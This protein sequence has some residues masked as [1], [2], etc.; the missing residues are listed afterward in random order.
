VGPAVDLRPPPASELA[1]AE[2]LDVALAHAG[3]GGRDQMS[4]AR[5]VARGDVAEGR[6]VDS[7]R[8]RDGLLQHHLDA[9]GRCARR[10]LHALERAPPELR[11]GVQLV[12][13]GR[14]LA[15][16]EG[17]GVVAAAVRRSLFR[18][19]TLQRRGQGEDLRAAG[20]VE[21]LPDRVADALEQ[22]ERG[23]PRAGC[24][25]LQLAD[26]LR[27]QR[28]GVTLHVALLQQA[29]E[30]LADDH[31]HLLVL[32]KHRHHYIFEHRSRIAR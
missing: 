24:P 30:L 25:G 4:S 16:L 8:D 23:L 28:L 26:D 15:E 19:V 32:A 18:G 13:A 29:L 20:D 7:A 22:R 11:F 10:D 1:P 3:K 17:P 27:G 6:G 2:P 14:D 31:L 12:V 21:H 5:G 9:A